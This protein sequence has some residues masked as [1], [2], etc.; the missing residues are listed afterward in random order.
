MLRTVLATWLAGGLFG[1]ALGAAHSELYALRNLVKLPLLITT[2]AVVCSVSYWLLARLLTVPLSFG[3]VQRAAW[4]IYRDTAVLLASLSPVVLFHARV[5]RATDDG[6]LGGYDWLLGLGMLAVAVAGS[7]SVV[8]QTRELL[9]QHRLPAN[10]ARAL[11]VGWL[12]LSLAV[13]GQAAF[14]LRPL[15]GFPASRGVAD[16]PF[17]LG[18]SPDLRG[19]TNFYEAVWQTIQRPPLPDFGRGSGR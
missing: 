15:F 19:A 13:G 6:R 14:Y 5:L 3:G 7:L 2:T 1:Y 10:T 16:P 12:A 18:A 4:E 8:R 11:V 17:L 9:R